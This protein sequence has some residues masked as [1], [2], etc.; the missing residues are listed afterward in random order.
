MATA[1]RPRSAADEAASLRA[2]K[3]DL[4]ES[5]RAEVT[6]LLNARLADAI[7]LQAM[8]KQ[9]H[10]NVRGPQFIALHK[11]FDEVHVAV[12]EYVDLI[13][14]RIT[15]LGGTA[16]GTVKVAAERSTLLDYPVT[17][18]TGSD[19]VAALSDV[20][21]QFARES[22]LAIDEMTE[23][24]DAASADIF[25]EIARGVDKWLWFVEVHNTDGAR[26]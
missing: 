2:T 4:P 21:A 26:A 9:A 10:W 22:R 24:S 7:D 8:C 5:T 13:A 1:T 12:G 18:S 19:H 3:N 14:E 11:L 25:T 6:R 15:Q 20:L 23:L 16:E 17:I